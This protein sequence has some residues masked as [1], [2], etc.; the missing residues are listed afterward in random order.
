MG[1]YEELESHFGRLTRIEE[2]IGMLHWDAATMMPAGGAEARSEQLATLRVIA[3]EML[4]DPK[5]AELIAASH[6]NSELDA[7]QVANLKEMGRL[8]LHSTTVPAEL[9]DKLSRKGSACEMVWRAARPD[10]DF[11]RLQPYLKAVLE[12]TREVAVIKGE[13]F[14]CSPYDALLDQYEP[15]GAS[16]RIDAIFDDL[17]EFLPG[18]LEAVLERQ[19]ARPP[20]LALDGPFAIEAQRSLAIRL[21]TKLGFDFNYGRLDVS[22]HPF[23]GGVPDDVRITTAYNTSDFLRG[24]MGVLHETGHA[25]YERGLPAK[26]RYQ[27]VGRARGMSLHESQSLLVEMQACRSEQFVSYVAPLAGEAFGKSGAPWQA[28]NL[29]RHVTRVSRGLIRVHADEVTYPAHVILRYRLEKAMVAGDLQIAELPGAWAEGMAALLGATPPDD[30]DGCMQDIH[31]MDGAFGYFP[32]YTLGAM[33]AAQLFQSAQASDPDVLDGLGR[34]DFSPLMSWMG[35]HVHAKGSL[36]S[37]DELLTEATGQPLD[38]SF[39]KAHL[40]NRY[41]P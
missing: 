37:T 30:R 29:Y 9:V 27:P 8:W 14:K 15:G 21:M 28:D 35:E 24:M 31:W 22:V 18:F 6:E 38:A 12:L 40:K 11:K 20:A 41:L 1:A 5:L 7:W 32:T 23:C 36:L 2:A 4:T 13:A 17:A 39:F 3:H 10:N 33:T 16:V 25:L 19:A 26:W 34:G